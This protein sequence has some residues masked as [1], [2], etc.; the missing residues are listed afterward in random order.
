MNWPLWTGCIDPPF[1]VRFSCFLLALFPESLIISFPS[2]R[3]FKQAADS[4]CEELPGTDYRK[5]EL[6]SGDL[7]CPCCLLPVLGCISVLSFAL[8]LKCLLMV[9][10]KAQQQQQERHS[11][12]S[13]KKWCLLEYGSL[14]PRKMLVYKW[15]TQMWC[16]V[17][18]NRQRKN[19]SLLHMPQYPQCQK[20]KQCCGSCKVVRWSDEY[21]QNKACRFQMW[22]WQTEPCIHPAA[23]MHSLK[24]KRCLIKWSGWFMYSLSDSDRNLN[25]LRSSQLYLSCSLY[26]VLISNPDQQYAIQSFSRLWSL[27]KNRWQ[28]DRIA[29][30]DLDEKACTDSASSVWQGGDHLI[31]D[32]LQ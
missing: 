22:W 23:S 20:S 11:G 16:C 14:K 2:K 4:Q 8:L 31:C 10:Y 3:S 30:E 12:T 1:P 28:R 7:I 6:C 9:G 26:L 13:E 21:R 19:H 24:S 29:A 27:G 5:F 25:P 15:L 18:I 17:S 32:L